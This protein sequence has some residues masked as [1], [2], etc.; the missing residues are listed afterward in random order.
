[1][2]LLYLFNSF[3]TKENL[4]HQK[5]KLLLAVSGGLDSVVLCELCYRSG[6]DF[7]I[8]HCNFQ[9][10]GQESTRDEHFVKQLAEKYQK[11]FFIKKFDTEKY[12]LENKISI[13]V[14]ARRLRYAWFAE[15]VERGEMKDDR[16]DSKAIDP[17][18]STIICLLTAH[19]LNDNI[20]TLLMNFFV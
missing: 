10:R 11:E 18:L 20:E 4:F 1:M 6:F 17:Q 15:L 8:A 2:N 9:L 12:A 16:P 7:A 14:A 13:Q 3:I 5:D 19:H